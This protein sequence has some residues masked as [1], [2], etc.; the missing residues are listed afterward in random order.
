MCRQRA[1]AGAGAL[2][3]TAALAGADELAAAG[4]A[5]GKAALRCVSA[6]AFVLFERDGDI[7]FAAA[8]GGAF[9]S[10]AAR[11]ALAASGLSLIHI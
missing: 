9:A 1:L 8:D 10:G 2:A 6:L 4:A 7:G 11:V 5:G 3:G